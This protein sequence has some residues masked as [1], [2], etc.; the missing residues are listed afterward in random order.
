[1][2]LQTIKIYLLI[3]N[4]IINFFINENYKG[5]N[6]RVNASQVELF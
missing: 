6:S 1:M 4:I 3:K 5:Y 2:R